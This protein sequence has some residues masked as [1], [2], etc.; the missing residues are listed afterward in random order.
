MANIHDKPPASAAP[1]IDPA[2]VESI[3]RMFRGLRGVVLFMPALPLVVL[4]AMW[5]DVPASWLLAWLVVTMSI[6][7]IRYSIVQRYLAR[8]VNGE[9]VLHWARMIAVTAA[10]D[11]FAWGGAVLMFWVPHSAPQQMVLLTMIVGI[12]AGSIFITSYFPLTQYAYS[13]PAIGLTILTLFLE[14]ST[15]SL[16]LAGGMAVYLVIQYQLVRGAHRA[17]MDA[18]QLRFENLDLIEQ[19][20]EQ[21]RA[22]EQSNI[23]KSRFLAAASHDLRQPLHALGLYAATLDERVTD[24]Q[25]RAL[26]E[27]INR[28]IAALEDLFNALLDISR[29]DAG[30]VEPH[31]EPLRIAGVLERLS[32][33]YAPQAAAKQLAW[34]CDADDVAVLTDA[35]LVETVLRNLIGNAIR[36]TEQG[37][38]A[39][40]CAASDK[41]ARITITDTGIGIP[42]EHHKDA[43]T[44]FF[45]LHNPERDRTKGL[46]L[47]LAIVRRVTALLGHNLEF[48]SK[49][50]R[51]TIFAITLPRAPADAPVRDNN[52]EAA[53]ELAATPMRILVIDDEML[54]RD[55]MTT[56]LTGWGYTVMAAGSAEEAIG[57]AAE[58]PDVII[59]DYRLRDGKTGAEAIQQFH[60]RWDKDIPALIVTGDTAPERLRDAQA[61]GFTLLHKPVVP[62]KLRAFLRSSVKRHPN[63]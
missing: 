20:R 61:T 51:G 39:V 36:Y 58:R 10:V 47:G 16:G 54:V 3:D 5:G 34:S 35:A 25:N 55:A 4:A 19:L 49:P 17:N 27:N 40:R 23:A 14:G 18:I 6:P 43:F 1:D 13:I 21:T 32:N 63:R 62:A 42:P 37:G 31:I 45:Q 12:A 15:A 33:D 48:D 26:V 9:A 28:S 30:I 2:Q 41:D 52:A 8:R 29:L 22:A 57:V 53:M 59:A 60:T 44:E 50:G 56:L 11:G 38:V 24:P 46:G 7:L